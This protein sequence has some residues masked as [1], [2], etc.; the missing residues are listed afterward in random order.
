MAHH[1]NGKGDIGVA[2]VCADLT[3][4]NIHVFV[5]AFSGHL[6]YDL[7]ADIE[8][9]LYKVQSKYRAPGK[10][11]HSVHVPSKTSWAN[12][13]GAQSAKYVEGDFDFYAIWVPTLARVLY[14]PFCGKGI[15]IAT[16]ES[17]TSEYYW[18]EDF[19]DLSF[20]LPPRRP[21][22]CISPDYE[23]RQRRRARQKAQGD[24]V[25]A[26][27]RRNTNAGHANWP[28]AAVLAKLVWKEPTS[29]I[30]K[31]LGVSDKA[32]E[33]HC[34][35]LGIEKPPRGY[36][37]KA[38]SGRARAEQPARRTKTDW[39]NAD[40]LLTM[41]WKEPT[42]AIAARLGVSDKAVEKHCRRHGIEKPPRG[43]WAKAAAG[44]RSAAD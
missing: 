14:V 12:S 5:P 25:T 7:I 8:G 36:W 40:V 18:W 13:R 37:A 23:S 35:K 42:T 38:A 33:K 16:K 9:R 26:M 20:T 27:P 3:E 39:P 31:R 29:T 11:G 41:V 21:R 44:S 19:L 10:R 17:R 15:S 4:R 28:T 24:G 32:V 2:K 1:T 30:A 6:K 22:T 43:Y 34:R